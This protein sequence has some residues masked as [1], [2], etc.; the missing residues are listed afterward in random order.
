MTITLIFRDNI[1][2]HSWG[3]RIGITQPCD[4]SAKPLLQYQSNQAVRLVCHE[5]RNPQDLIVQSQIVRGEPDA[6]HELIREQF[7]DLLV[8]PVVR[9]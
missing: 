9:S 5:Q 7:L 3:I 4:K 8:L 6:E 1:L 2:R